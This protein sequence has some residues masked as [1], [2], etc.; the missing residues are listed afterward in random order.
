MISRYG[1]IQ[2]MTATQ[3][4]TVLNLQETATQIATT[5]KALVRK[6][7]EEGKP[8]T[9]TASQLA[10]K[11]P[12]LK[13]LP[14][15]LVIFR[16]IETRSGLVEGQ[17]L[18]VWTD[19]D[20]T[21]KLFSPDLTPITEGVEF[22][23][24]NSG[25]SGFYE[26]KLQ[27]QTFRT[28]FN[29]SQTHI[30]QLVSMQSKGLDGEGL[31]PNDIVAPVPQPEIPIYSDVLPQNVPLEVI[32]NNKVSRKYETPMITVKAPN[33]E[34]FK[35]VICNSALESLVET[36]GIG[37]KF[38]IGDKA[39]RVNKEG[40]PIDANGKVNKLK[41]SYIVQIID[42]QATDFSDLTI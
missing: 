20:T 30:K 9:L 22:L 25:I 31:A 2:T 10:A 29:P 5:A 37:A 18:A 35:N 16:L 34:T 26:F 7:R 33:G 38:K 14:P 41:P 23:S 42:L 40:Q 39:P 4:A 3:K 36:H 13:K 21:V 6:V 19:E 27:G 12:Q 24:Y 17:S 15:D 8:V 32:S 1:D 28:G 11:I